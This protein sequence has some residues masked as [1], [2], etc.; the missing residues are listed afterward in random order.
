MRPADIA[1]LVGL[2]AL[3]VGGTALVLWQ[4][5][6]APGHDASEIAACRE[7][8]EVSRE[9]ARTAL[10]LDERLARAPFVLARIGEV[11]PGDARD[12]YRQARRGASGIMESEYDTLSPLTDAALLELPAVD[13]A[14]L[15]ARHASAVS[16]LRAVGHHEPVTPTSDLDEAVFAGDDPW[17]IPN[18]SIALLWQARAQPTASACFEEVLDVARLRQVAM[19]EDDLELGDGTRAIGRL[20]A[21]AFDHCAAR[22]SEAELEGAVRDA[23]E[24]S[25]HPIPLDVMLQ[26]HWRDAAQDATQFFG[27][28]GPD[29]PEWEWCSQQAPPSVRRRGVEQATLALELTGCVGVDEAGLAIDWQVCARRQRDICSREECHDFIEGAWQKAAEE[30]VWHRVMALLASARLLHVRGALPDEGP[31]ERLRPALD[32]PLHGEPIGYRRAGD[33]VVFTLVDAPAPLT[34]TLSARP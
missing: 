9:L 20:T 21:V 34:I 12:A 15:L 33:H 19:L 13:L 10:V 1:L 2:A 16:A 5:A 32:D 26:L 24:L 28:Y 8:D 29:V 14:P 11:L 4:R 3:G 22:A 30:Q 18:L 7:H 27:H 17:A 6:A 23:T 31:P 25:R